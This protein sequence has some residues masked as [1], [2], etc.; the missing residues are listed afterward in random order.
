MKSSSSGLSGGA[1][2]GSAE[3]RTSRGILAGPGSHGLGCSDECFYGFGDLQPSGLISD[4]GDEA[5]PMGVHNRSA[6]YASCNLMAPDSD[7]DPYAAPL[8]GV[9]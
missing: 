8:A 3:Q 1:D 4:G 7:A 5:F 2:D 9:I 6:A